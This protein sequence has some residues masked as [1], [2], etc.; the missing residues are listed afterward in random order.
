MFYCNILKLDVLY[1][2]QAALC[3]FLKNTFFVPVHHGAFFSSSSGILFKSYLFK[4][5]Y[6]TSNAPK[7]SKRREK[8]IIEP[9]VSID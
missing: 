9:K 5:Y 2:S 7:E 3:T 8:F 1:M 6:V 4:W